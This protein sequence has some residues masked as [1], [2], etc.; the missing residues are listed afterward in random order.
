MRRFAVG[1]WAI[2]L[3]FSCVTF[4]GSGL[5]IVFQNTPRPVTLG[6][7]V[8]AF[9]LALSEFTAKVWSPILQGVFACGVLNCVIMLMSG[10]VIGQPEKPIPQ[11]QVWI[12]TG[13]LIVL[14]ALAVRLAGRVKS[15]DL[16]DRI[17]FALLVVFLSATFFFPTDVIRGVGVIGMVGLMFALLIR[18][19]RLRRARSAPRHE[20]DEGVL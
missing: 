9:S 3:L 13:C 5:V 10:H 18:H 15:L 16:V 11:P 14:T 12:M 20:V 17:A 6:W 7:L 4:V 8:L 19:P 1:V 2:L